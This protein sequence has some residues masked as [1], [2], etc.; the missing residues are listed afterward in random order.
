MDKVQ[1]TLFVDIFRRHQLLIE[2]CGTVRSESNEKL[3]DARR[4]RFLYRER[5]SRDLDRE[6]PLSCPSNECYA[7]DTYRCVYVYASMKAWPDKDR[8]F[9][10]LFSFSYALR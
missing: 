9:V 2:D 10:N 3:S 7:N 1:L 6:W 5:N 4:Q 8:Q